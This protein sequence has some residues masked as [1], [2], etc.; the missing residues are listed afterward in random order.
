MLLLSALIVVAGITCVV[1]AVAGGDGFEMS[2]SAYGGGC[3]RLERGG[4]V[5]V[6]G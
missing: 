3:G 2:F 4:C 6:V 1:Y 5:A